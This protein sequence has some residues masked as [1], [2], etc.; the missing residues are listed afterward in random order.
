MVVFLIYK[1]IFG[2][3]FS[4]SL[5]LGFLDSRLPIC[6]SWCS[7]YFLFDIKFVFNFIF[8]KIIE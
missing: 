4:F 1:M 8:L 5:G 7:S 6:G 3:Y 2:F